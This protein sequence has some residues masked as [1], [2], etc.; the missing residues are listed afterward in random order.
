MRHWPKTAIAVFF[1]AAVTGLAPLAAEVTNEPVQAALSVLPRGF[2]A[3]RGQWDPQAAWSA[4]GF[5]GTTWVTRDGELR[6]VL[7]R[8]DK[9]DSPT[10]G[11][12]ARGVPRREKPCPA[13]SWVLAE[14]FVGGTVREMRGEQPLGTQVSYFLGRDASK[15]RSGLESF[16]RVSLGEVW[17]GV[18]VSLKA[19]QKTVEKIFTVRPF[20]DPSRIRVSLKGTEELTLND[21]GELLVTTGYG[22]VVFS[23]PVAWQE[24]G[25]ARTPVEVSYR[26]DEKTQTYGFA[27]GAY[28]KE[29]P[30]IIDPILQSTYLGGTSDDVASALA[31]SGEVYVAG[32]TYSTNFPGT[33]GGAQATYGGG[34]TDAFVAQLNSSLTTLNQ[35]TYLGGSDDDSALA[36]A[37]A[38]SGEVYVAGYTDSN[39]FPGT[40]GGAQASN[41]GDLD[42][43]VAQL[44]SSLTTLNQATYLGDS[45][46]DNAYALALA[47]SGEVYVAGWTE[48]T[49]FPGTAGG[50]QGNNGGDLDAFVARLSSSLTTL[51]QAT[52]LG[53]S[54]SD[55]A[56]ALA[57]AASGEVYVAGWTSSTN[58]PGTTGGAQA[59]NGGGGDA[60]VAWLSSSLT[61]L[62]QATYLGGSGDDRASALA[63]AASGEVYVAGWTSSTNFPGTSG[64]A[65]A[66]NGG[67]RDAFV[68]RLNTDL[69]TLQQATY[70]GDSDRDEAYALA[71]AASGEV[72]VA[73]WTWSTDFP[74]TT[75][76]AQAS[77]AGDIDAFVA[78]LSSSLTTL[79]QA[80]Y[81]GGSGSDE[82]RALALA[83]TGEVYVAGRTS[84]TNFPGTSGGAQASY[85]GRG[86]AFVA[87]LSAGLAAATTADMVANA[88]SVPLPLAPGGSYT[89]SF[90]CTNSGPDSATNAT[91]SMTASAGTVSGV[92]CTPAVPVASLA[93]GA[94]IACTCT[95]TAPGSQGGGN[96]TE[97]GV[98]FTVSASSDTSDPDSTNN[99]ATSGATPI[100]IVDALSDAVT[101]PAGT[102]GAT[103]N[104][105]SN[106]Q[107]GTGSLPA[108]ASFALGAGTTCTGASINASTGVATFN[109]PAS[110]SCTVNYQVCVI[111]GC[112]TASLTVTAQQAEAIPTLDDWGLWSL[113]VLMSGVGILLLRRW[114]A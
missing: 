79:N 45:G 81:L 41:G 100:P 4:P 111:S 96:T 99:T 17:P 10:E 103:F 26:L 24:A 74:G 37:L 30:L 31:A 8:A 94:T 102:V 113:M 18:E 7:L 87:R 39:N 5:F 44:N 13:R 91:C 97:T 61:T 27:L 14:R 114:V 68:A 15:H 33:S 73:G 36:L 112:D 28:D 108:G 89:L 46:W 3:N 82:A 67:F 40:T 63:L 1:V 95:F 21:Q 85:G 107:Y 78:R 72:Y 12:E 109:V 56:R 62:N 48:S 32:W 77:N 66:S 29:K 47:A 98:T 101:L 59:S 11:T 34:F 80:T 90:S 84:S 51:N 35:A 9:C 70:L 6:H 69:K 22:D 50:A 105:G 71:L 92:S 20:A 2:V 64:G 42:A 93:P 76:G 53:G 88:P 86:D 25:G 19:G 65:Q 38:A 75:G 16:G 52:Y 104:V 55:E 23:K 57:L 54:G 110:G 58:F 49:D 106:D 60:F 43:F 83:A